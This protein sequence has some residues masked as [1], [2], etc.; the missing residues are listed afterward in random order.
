MPLLAYLT[1]IV[2]WSTTPLV[3]KLGNDSVTPITAI[4]LRMVLAVAL[5]FVILALMRKA[6]IFDR[7]NFKLYIAGSIGI[8]PNMVM[9]YYASLYIPSGLLAVLMGLAPFM[10]GF[11]AHF[12]LGDVFFIRRKILGQI[13]A[14]SGLVVVYYGQLSLDADSTIGVLLMLCSTAI[15]ATSSV[16]VKKFSMQRSVSSLNQTVG[17][18]LFS[19]PGL[20]L[21]WWLLDGN[22]DIVISDT[23]L[24]SI[25]YLAIVGSLL[26]FVVFFYV[27]KHMSVGLVTLILLITPVSALI[28]GKTVADEVISLPIVLGSVLILAGLIMYENIFKLKFSVQE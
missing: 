26:G 10:T 5:G 27:M 3:I 28:L 22:T 21:S 9:V 13:L 11:V 1:A 25:L 17:A 8:F 18:M 7:R 12:V 6:G 15:F 24:W 2:I 4:T 14:L 19:L 20:L 23:S 16:F